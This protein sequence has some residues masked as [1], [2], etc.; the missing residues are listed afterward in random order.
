DAAAITKGVAAGYLAYQALLDIYWFWGY[1]AGPA[2]D[3]Y[4]TAIVVVALLLL[5]AGVM[6]RTRRERDARTLRLRTAARMAQI[7]LAVGINVAV[8]TFLARWR[9]FYAENN[10]ETYY[11]VSP[12]AQ[13]PRLA[14][15]LLVPS[16]LLVVW[17]FGRTRAT[18]VALTTLASVASVAYITAAFDT[19][20][21]VTGT[22]ARGEFIFAAAAAAAIAGITVRNVVSSQTRT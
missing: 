5:G 14:L 15:L 10:T 17:S 21:S 12:N 8:V 11:W 2:W 19:G 9:R 20:D 6:F 22:V 3:G 18:A 16:L 4:R 13:L 1:R 7:V